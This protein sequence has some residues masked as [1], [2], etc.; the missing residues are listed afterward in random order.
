METRTTA[1]HERPSRSR[2]RT[3]NWWKIGCIVSLVALEIAREIIVLMANQPMQVGG[4]PFVHQV[5]STILAQGRWK[6]LEG[7]DDLVPAAVTIECS[8]ERKECIQASTTSLMDH[9]FSTPSISRFP[10]SFADNAVSFTNDVPACVTYTTRIDLK[11]QKVISVR[12]R[13]PSTATAGANCDMI[14]ER[15]EL[16]LGEGWRAPDTGKNFVPLVSGFLWMLGLFD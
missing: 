8:V 10:A 1:D 16:A 13:K 6:P 15:L 9:T 5:G 3:L 7:K 12:E 4:A 11:L 2:W 14:E